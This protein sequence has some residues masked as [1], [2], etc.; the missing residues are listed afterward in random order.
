[1]SKS[2]VRQLMAFSRRQMATPKLININVVLADLHPLIRRLIPT[3]IEIGVVLDPDSPPVRADVGQIEQ[4]IINL[5]L[6]ARDA[7]AKGGRL[8]LRTEHVHVDELTIVD[9]FPNRPSDAVAISVTDTGIGM[10]PE[11]Q[12]KIFEPFFTT[13][14]VGKGVGLGLSTVYG[15][16]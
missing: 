7:M 10:S 15:I 4:I 1:R 9:G 6:N 3:N 16:V 13:K 5:A 11:L 14:D 12:E 8:T 2:F